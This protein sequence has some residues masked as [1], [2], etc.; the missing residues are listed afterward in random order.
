MPGGHL[1]PGESL[2]TSLARELVEELGLEAQVG[3][4][5]GAV[6]HEYGNAAEMHYEINH[7]FEVSLPTLGEGETPSSREAHLN[8]FWAKLDALTGHGLEPSPLRRLL[9]EK[10]PSALWASMLPSAS[11]L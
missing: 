11:D 6:E 1:E 10:T 2:K 9:K 5:L 4:Y 8:F 3:M 7:L